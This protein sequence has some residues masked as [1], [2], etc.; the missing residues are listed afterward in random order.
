MVPISIRMHKIESRDTSNR[1]YLS[2]TILACRERQ[3]KKP[4]CKLACRCLKETS[5][6]FLWLKDP[7]LPFIDSGNLHEYRFCRVPF[8]VISSPF[9][10]VA[11]VIYDLDNYDSELAKQLRK[12]TFAW[13][14]W[15]QVLVVCQKLSPCT[16][17]NKRY[18]TML[19]WISANG[20]L[21]NQPSVKLFIKFIF[22]S[23][24]SRKALTSK[25]L[26]KAFGLGWYIMR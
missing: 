26:G 4:F 16:K 6:D 21:T 22:A 5:L 11:T 24:T 12:K 25:Y 20:Q 7:S 10:L 9:L 3:A 15:L 18:F 14:T 17:M 19:T 2:K 1:K 23:H 8:G 13:I